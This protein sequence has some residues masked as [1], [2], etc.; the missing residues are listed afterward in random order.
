VA[1]HV[2]AD[3]VMALGDVAA[4]DAL[5]GALAIWVAALIAGA[6]FVASTPADAADRD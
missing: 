4:P 1:P 3:A 2:L 5:V 6:V